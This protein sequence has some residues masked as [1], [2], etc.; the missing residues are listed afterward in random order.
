MSRFLA[1]G[2]ASDECLGRSPNSS[3]SLEERLQVCLTL[4]EKNFVIKSFSGRDTQPGPGVLV[5]YQGD[6]GRRSG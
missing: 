1:S 4:V 3:K 6:L 5:R 2:V